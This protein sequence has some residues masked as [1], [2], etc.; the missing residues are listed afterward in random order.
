MTKYYEN[1]GRTIKAIVKDL[2]NAGQAAGEDR[3]RIYFTDYTQ[4]YFYVNTS[5]CEARYIETDDDIEDII[6]GDLLY[7]ETKETGEYKVIKNKDHSEDYHEIMFLEIATTRG[8][9]TYA[10]H[11][12]HNGAYSGFS[13]LTFVDKG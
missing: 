10:A 12:I 13:G 5:C 11:N 2:A 1:D 3:V 7:I 9:I 4:L 8:F 6:G